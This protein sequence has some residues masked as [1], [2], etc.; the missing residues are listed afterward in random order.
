MYT[1]LLIYF[2][3][4]C[5]GFFYAGT[6]KEAFQTKDIFAGLIG[7]VFSGFFWVSGFGLFAYTA[8]DAYVYR[9]DPAMATGVVTEI[10]REDKW[11]NRTVSID[12]IK[13]KDTYNN[14]KLVEGERVYILYYPRTRIINKVFSGVVELAEIDS[15]REKAKAYKELQID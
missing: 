6:V 9:S 5:L 11:G 3:F 12:D 2:I 13:L 14:P 15:A 8:Y 4:G 7:L 1:A 10:A